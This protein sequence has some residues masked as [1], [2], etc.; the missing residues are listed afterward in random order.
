MI[1]QVSLRRFKQFESLDVKLPGHV[2]LAGPNNGGKTTLLQAIAAWDLALRRWREM[3]NRA[4][5][6]GAYAFC[7]IARPDFLAVPLPLNGLDLLWTGRDRERELEI[8][9]RADGWSVTMQ[10]RFDDEQVLVRPAAATPHA[11][12]TRVDLAVVYVPPMGGLAPEEPHYAQDEFLAGR[13]AEGRPGEVLRN[14]L[15][16]ASS[17]AK[18]WKKLTDLVRRL[19]GHELEP[20]RAG[21]FMSANYRSGGK[22]FDLIS[23]GSGFQQV[24]M[25]AAVLVTRPGSVLLID[26]PDAH[27]HVILQDA[28]FH[29]LHALAHESGAQLIVST[30]SEVI[31]NSVDPTQ[32]IAMPAARAI[33]DGAQRDALVTGLG[34]LSNTD[35]MLARSVPGILYVEGHTDIELLRAW[36]AALGHP[37]LDVLTKQLLWHRYSTTARGELAA[38][39]ASDHYRALRLLA[40]ELRALEIQDRDGNP[41]LQETL[42][43]GSGFQIV[44]WKRCEIESYLV[45]PDALERFVEH[46]VGS[47]AASESNRS[48]L[49]EHLQ[50]TYPPQVLKSPLDDHPMLNGTKARV[51]LLPPALQAAGL[52]IEY[53]EFHEIAALMKPEEIHPEVVQKLDSICAAF[54]IPLP[55][56][57]NPKQ[58]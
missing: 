39:K 38:F 2:V 17:D 13:F 21:R 35:A 47:G 11:E 32:L 9:V 44:R 54:G 4:R 27:L 19:F 36:A 22:S 12:P 28:I 24:L 16:R 29:E 18:A 57:P 45:H 41:H 33:M 43:S 31:V 15:F 8:G 55:P 49:R 26:E 46:K 25:L 10:F 53:G 30:H 5:P 1:R 56:S 37:V 52:L 40:P 42:V 48:A 7:P 51:D 6:A 34:L 23:A 20:P 58:P 3:N 50:A 14:L